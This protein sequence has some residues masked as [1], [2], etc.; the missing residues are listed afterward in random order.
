MSKQKPMTHLPVAYPTSED[1]M[2]SAGHLIESVTGTQPL[3]Q[4]MV[5]GHTWVVASAVLGRVFPP[6]GPMMGAS[7]KEVKLTEDECKALE[8]FK[9]MNSQV[10]AGNVAAIDWDRW[11]AIG[12]VVLEIL[13]RFI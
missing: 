8:E 11:R 10:Q 9:V 1:G 13:L 5:V 12:R 3:S 7:G 6:D 4:N 2:H